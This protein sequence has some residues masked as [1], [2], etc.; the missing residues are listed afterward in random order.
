MKDEDK[1]RLRELGFHLPERDP[2]SVCLHS[3]TPSL[4]NQW[5]YVESDEVLESFPTKDAGEEEDTALDGSLLRA[6]EYQ[7][8]ML[9]EML[10]RSVLLQDLLEEGGRETQGH[11][12]YTR[13][14]FGN[15]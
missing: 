2:V 1:Q 11:S 14:V 3:I 12:V 10:D 6:N 13:R 4:C 15:R 9:E 8:Q 5:Y 7:Q